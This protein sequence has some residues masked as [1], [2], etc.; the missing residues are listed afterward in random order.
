MGM[1]PFRTAGG[2]R[3]QGDAAVGWYTRAGSSEKEEKGRAM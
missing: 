2:Y 1:E 3:G